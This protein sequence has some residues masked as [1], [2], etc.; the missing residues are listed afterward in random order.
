MNQ[1]V[2]ACRQAASAQA[3]IFTEDSWIQGPLKP[4]NLWKFF[5]RKN[6]CLYF[7]RGY[8]EIWEIE[9]LP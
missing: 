3:R 8:D 7:G 2:P 5:R 6:G 4:T 9:G 1:G